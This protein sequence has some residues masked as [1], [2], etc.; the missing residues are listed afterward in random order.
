MSYKN[1]LSSDLNNTN[2]N[3]Q[4]RKI[5]GEIIHLNKLNKDVDFE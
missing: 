5:V 2:E 4:S 3:T 1:L